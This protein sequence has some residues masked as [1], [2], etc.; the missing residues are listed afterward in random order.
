MSNFVRGYDFQTATGL[1]T[2]TELES[3]VTD[4]TLAAGAFDDTEANRI[5]DTRKFVPTNDPSGTPANNVLGIKPGGIEQ[6]DISTT[7]QTAIAEQAVNRSDLFAGAPLIPLDYTMFSQTL[8]Y[9]NTHSLTSIPYDIDSSFNAAFDGN[10]ATYTSE[11]RL[12][13]GS[14]GTLICDLGAVYT[15]FVFVTQY[16]TKIGDG[17]GKVLLRSLTATQEYPFLDNPPTT[18]EIATGYAAPRPRWDWRNNN[19]PVVNTDKTEN[20]LDGPKTINI[21]FTGQYITM[22]DYVYTINSAGALDKISN[23][24]V[25]GRQG[26]AQAS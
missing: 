12:R 2:G 5:F 7:A 15:G 16:S 18:P 23:F 6:G 26:I 9:V 10:P 14:N 24:S 17:S 21:M 22:Q 19:N 1:K 11:R 4:A 20:K 25:Y 8:S 3:L 13:A